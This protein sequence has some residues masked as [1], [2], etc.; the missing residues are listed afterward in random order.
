MILRIFIILLVMG[1]NVFALNIPDK[2]DSRVIDQ[3][4]TL[5]LGQKQVLIDILDNIY[6]TE[7]H[8]E[9]QILM[10]PSLDNEPIEDISIKIARKWKIGQKNTNNGAL[11]LIAINDHKY[12]IEVGYGLEGVLPDGYIGNLERNVMTPYFAK[13]DFFNGLKLAI[14][15]LGREVSKD[16]QTN[17]TTNSRQLSSKNVIIYVLVGIVV[18][19]IFAALA[20]LSGNPG[21][22]RDVLWFILKIITLAAL[23]RGGG[24]G[25]SRNNDDNIGGGGDFGGGGSQGKW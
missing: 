3:T 19:V 6:N 20:A 12:R 24:S 14:N 16:Y 10:I 4:N 11:I 1:A 23:F 2:P 7:S 18:F 5:T 22:I 8:T 21:Q 15:D 17:L 25:N 9:I 13:N